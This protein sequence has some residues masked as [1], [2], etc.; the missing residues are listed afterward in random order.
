MT[1]IGRKIANAILRTKVIVQGHVEDLNNVA[2]T[3]N[4][5]EVGAEKTAQVT[6]IK[7]AEV[8]K[9]IPR[10]GTRMRE[11]TIKGVQAITKRGGLWKL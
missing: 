2:K 9:E 8:M 6:G 10:T 7:I 5:V 1:E 3:T 11:H 4:A